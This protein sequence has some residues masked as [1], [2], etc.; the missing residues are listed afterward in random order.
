MFGGR[1]I[2]AGMTDPN[3]SAL[4]MF[5]TTIGIYRLKNEGLI[6][7]LEDAIWM[8]EDGDEAGAA[9]CE[10]Q[11]YDGYTSYASLDDL[12]ARAT[13]FAELQEELDQFVSAFAEKLYWDLSSQ[14][15]VLDSLWVNILAPGAAHSSHIHPNS[16]VSGT[17]YIDLPDAAGAIKFE[18]PRLDKMM[19]APPVKSDTPNAHQRFYTRNPEAGDVLLWES[20]LR[21]EVMPNRSEDPRLSISFNYGLESQR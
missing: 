13:A 11:G 10:Q 6:E 19:A 21:H 1:G 5:P 12:P 16:V 15:L 4:L 20:W 7:A 3:P 14:Q 18:D 8:L 17:A 9:W 2:D